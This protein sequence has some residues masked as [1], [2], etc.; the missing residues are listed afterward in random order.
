MF[1]SQLGIGQQTQN[2]VVGTEFML[3]LKPVGEITADGLSFN[4][5]RDGFGLGY[6]V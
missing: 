3:P 2:V 6:H 1:L 5:G 4:V